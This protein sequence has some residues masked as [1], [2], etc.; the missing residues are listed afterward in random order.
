MKIFTRREINILSSTI[1]ALAYRDIDEMKGQ[2]PEAIYEIDLINHFGHSGLRR[3]AQF[4][5]QTV[6]SMPYQSIESRNLWQKE[7]GFCEEVFD[8]L[9]KIDKE[10]ARIHYM[11]NKVEEMH[12]NTSTDIGE[13]PSK[14]IKNDLVSI[15][16][17][18]IDRR[19]TEKTIP[20]Q[21]RKRCYDIEPE[22][23]DYDILDYIGYYEIEY[24]D[25]GM[26]NKEYYKRRVN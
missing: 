3:Q 26:N 21:L 17:I 15:D 11:E 19:W 7:K 8:L 24:E 5:L 13:T 22:W 18:V 4:L 25:T 14:P 12:V 6:D 20:M 10:A 1:K 16:D 2:D 23:T 9:R